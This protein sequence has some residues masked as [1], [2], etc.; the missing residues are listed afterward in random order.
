MRLT[1]NEYRAVVL[2]LLLLIGAG[3]VIGGN[4]LF[5][6]SY[7]YH[8][9]LFGA[10]WMPKLGPYSQE[11]TQYAGA[12]YL[13]M[14]VPAVIALIRPTPRLL[15]AVGWLNAVAAFPHMVFHI[16]MEYM[17]G[18]AETIPQAGFLFI[19]V[20]A[21]IATAEIARTGQARYFATRHA[22][23]SARRYVFI[24][25]GAMKP[26]RT[27]KVR[28]LLVLLSIGYL[29]IAVYNMF[30][31]YHFYKDFFFGYDWISRLGDY[32]QHLTFDTGA[33]CGG[34]AAAAILAAIWLT[35]NVVRA[36]GWGTAVAAFPMVIYH[37]AE[38]HNEGPLATAVQASVLFVVAVSGLVL[39]SL[40]QP[41]ATAVTLPRVTTPA[42]SPQQ[43]A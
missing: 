7:F 29:I 6:P 10:D 23:D 13:G 33:L 28:R 8:H 41:A 42:P 9:F 40:A 35:P 37:I 30:F 11:M 38:L 14:T 19:T 26:S 16:S 17:S 27:H 2:L 21:G 15:I 43:Q 3:V 12:L 22:D 18:F 34:F 39:A 1:R 36:L 20:V 24:D 5:F 25:E 31:P 32:S 4:A